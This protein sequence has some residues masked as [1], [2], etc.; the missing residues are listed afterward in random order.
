MSGVMIIT[1]T[2]KGLGRHL[3]EHYLGLGW[4]VAGCSRGESDL[5]HPAYQHHVADVANEAAVV[6]MV[7]A[8]EKTHG[9]IDALV[10]NAGIA[11]MNHLLLTP[12]S[13]AQSLFETNFL[14][15]FL[16]L[17]EAAKVMVRSKAGRIVNFTTV[18]VP[19]DLEG[20]AIYAASKA[21]VES[22]T[23]IAAREFG[24]FGVTVNAVGPTPVPTDLTRTVPKEKLAALVARQA[25][26]RQGTPADV[27]NVVDF[28]LRPESGFV[29]GQVVYLGGVAP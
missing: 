16:F 20:E 7:R 26:A 29:T 5:T 21:A 12:R 2:R 6:A 28:F 24:S 8:V 25:I 22:L 23:R 9:R 18:A 4:Q 13:A 17:R 14:G 10:N 11:A 19:L 1:G 3:A 15:T 27:A